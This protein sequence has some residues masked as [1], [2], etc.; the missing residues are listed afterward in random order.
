MRYSSCLHLF[1]N[2]R[3][4]QVEIYQLATLQEESLMSTPHVKIK[5][6]QQSTKPFMVGVGDMC[7]VCQ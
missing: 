1:L 6:I 7:G 5:Y 4:L 2:R 3:N